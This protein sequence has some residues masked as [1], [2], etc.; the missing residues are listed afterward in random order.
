MAAFDVPSN[1]LHDLSH[2]TRALAEAAFAAGDTL[3]WLDRR[4]FLFVA[5]RQYGFD[6][7]SE[8]QGARR[9]LRRSLMARS[10]NVSWSQNSTSGLGATQTYMAMVEPANDAALGLELLRH[11]CGVCGKSLVGWS[12]STIQLWV[13][14]RVCKVRLTKQN[15]WQKVG[16]QHLHVI[17]ERHVKTRAEIWRW[18]K[19][20]EYEVIAFDLR[21]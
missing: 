13:T 20:G 4:D 14:S 12:R 16:G 6:F 8:K 3:R 1:F 17:W 19:W 11:D 21:C 5:S 9:A 18:N 7:I 2:E 15:A 10:G